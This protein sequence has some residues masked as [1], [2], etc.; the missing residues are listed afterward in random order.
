MK[1]ARFSEVTIF[2]RIM[3]VAFGR[4]KILNQLYLTL[5]FIVLSSQNCV[6]CRSLADHNKLQ[7]KNTGKIENI[8][9]IIKIIKS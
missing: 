8:P 5:K 4:N 9:T 7:L 1:K 3:Q 6:F 2:L